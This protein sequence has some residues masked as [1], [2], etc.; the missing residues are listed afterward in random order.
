MSTTSERQEAMRWLGRRMA[1]EGCF[2]GVRSGKRPRR[3]GDSLV[4]SISWKAT[5]AE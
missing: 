1:W 3:T 2:G 4:D 5:S